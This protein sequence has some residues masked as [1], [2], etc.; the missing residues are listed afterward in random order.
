[1][2]HGDE[3]HDGDGDDIR[4][5]GVPGDGEPHDEDSD[6]DEVHGACDGSRGGSSS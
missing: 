2:A 1:M 4:G 6:G 3:V 5:A